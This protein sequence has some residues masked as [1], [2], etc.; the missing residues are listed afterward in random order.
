MPFQNLLSLPPNI[1]NVAEDR[2][3]LDRFLETRNGVVLDDVKSWV[4]S[5]G[6]PKELTSPTPRRIE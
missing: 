6:L 3:R 5:W 1:L 2:R 4:A